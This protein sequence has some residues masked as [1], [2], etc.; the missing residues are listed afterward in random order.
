[1]KMVRIQPN[2]SLSFQCYFCGSRD[3]PCASKGPVDQN[4][5]REVRSTNSVRKLGSTTTFSQCTKRPK[6]VHEETTKKKEKRR[7]KKLGQ[8]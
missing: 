2:R 3:R 8:K 4:A 5:Y 7:H 6:W 1:M